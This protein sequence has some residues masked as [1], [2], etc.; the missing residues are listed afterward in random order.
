MI[1][2]VFGLIATIF[3]VAVFLAIAIGVVLLGRTW[4]RMS[5]GSI[6]AGPALVPKPA[7]HGLQRVPWDLHGIHHALLEQS[8]APLATLLARAHDLG[9]S[10]HVP[11]S[12]D[13][14]VGI[15]SVLDQ[16]EAALELPPLGTPI[17]P[18]PEGHP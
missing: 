12:A 10:I 16:L 3:P 2:E 1:N 11:D 18:P 8:P 17:P 14:T 13:T 5:S 4:S 6:G 9:V 15:E 7:Q